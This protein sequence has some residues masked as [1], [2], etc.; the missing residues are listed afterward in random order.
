MEAQVPAANVTDQQRREFVERM[1]PHAQAASRE[2]GVDAR[3]V[4]AQAALETGWGSSQPA[5]GSGSSHNY[6]GIK[7]GAS[8]NGARVTADT[9]EFNQGVAGTESAQFRAYGSVA[10]SMSDYVRLVGSSPRYAAALN[11]G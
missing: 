5:D 11:T 10:E 8:W 3:A 4:I 6:F 1:M 2:L 9:T 7:A